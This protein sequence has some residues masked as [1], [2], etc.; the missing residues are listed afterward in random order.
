M[1][2]F[3]AP[4]WAY[5]ENFW[6]GDMALSDMEIKLCEAYERQGRADLAHCVRN[7]RVHQLLDGYFGYDMYRPGRR[8][9]FLVS[10]HAMISIFNADSSP[11]ATTS[12]EQW[13]IE[14]AEKYDGDEG[15]ALVKKIDEQG[16]EARTRS[17]LVYPLQRAMRVVWKRCRSI[18]RMT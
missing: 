8:E 14:T 13:E 11:E 9:E 7:A 1:A 17:K 10:R 16:Y 18:V 4:R 5:P 6:A 2:A 3:G 15:L 12:V